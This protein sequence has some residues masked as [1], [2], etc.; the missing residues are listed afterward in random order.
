MDERAR[1]V[2]SEAFD[3]LDRTK[4]LV[5]DKQQD[6]LLLDAPLLRDAIPTGVDPRQWAAR[7]EK[8]RRKELTRKAAK[9]KREPDW[10]EWDARVQSQ[11]RAAIDIDG[12]LYDVIAQA[13]SDIR[14]AL[15]SEIQELRAEIGSLREDRG[16]VT[17]M[18]PPKVKNAR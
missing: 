11:I 14:F 8:E 5:E 1:Q 18:P 7:Q 15:R 13:I 16:N 3:T 2:L 17:V 9:A 10:S 6:P 12:V 4:R